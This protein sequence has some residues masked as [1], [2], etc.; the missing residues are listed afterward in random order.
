M[1]GL[2]RRSQSWIRNT[3]SEYPTEADIQ[4][5]AAYALE[6][7]VDNAFLVYPNLTAKKVM[8]KVGYV[9]VESIIFD[10]GREPAEA[11]KD[12]LASLLDRLGIEEPVSV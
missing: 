3:K 12:F 2:V 9:Q 4:Q 5:V 6:M 1:V 10:T 7:G 8:P 11:G